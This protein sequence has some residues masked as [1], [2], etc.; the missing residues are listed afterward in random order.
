MS[1][2]WIPRVVAT[3]CLMT[4]VVLAQSAPQQAPPS[5]NRPNVLERPW[6]SEPTGPYARAQAVAAERVVPP[7]EVAGG[8]PYPA[9]F[10]SPV[11]APFRYEPSVGFP[12]WE[13]P[14]LFPGLPFPVIGSAPGR[15]PSFGV[16]RPRF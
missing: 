7:T 1:R 13:G 6:T 10:R 8:S 3:C 4:G 12:G 9:A 5:P 16:R 11:P 2:R 15:I 14:V